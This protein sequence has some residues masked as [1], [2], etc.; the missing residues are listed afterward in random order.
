MG[1]SAC[2]A[3]SKHKMIKIG[4]PRCILGRL[5]GRSHTRQ[6]AY[7]VL[8]QQLATPACENVI[9]MGMRGIGSSA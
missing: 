2:D 1:H 7:S 6:A 8:S 4:L 5:G 3:S 9:P